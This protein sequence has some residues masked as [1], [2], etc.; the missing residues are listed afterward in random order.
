MTK[1]EELGKIIGLS[2]EFIE[3]NFDEGILDI[4]IALNKKGYY[5]IFSCEGH[6]SPKPDNKGKIGKWE[7]YLAFADTYKF[8]EYPPK[9][10]KYNN[11]RRFFYWNG[12]GEESRK[13]YLD[14]VLTWA[15]TLPTRDKKKVV[16]YH[17]LGRN[18]KQPNREPKLFYYGEDYEEIRCIMNRADISNYFDFELH[19]NIKYI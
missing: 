10:Y 16:V 3:E 2:A 8:K 1:A 19:E 14:N 7:G 13:E 17:L 18:K 6:C 4:L 15:R 12:Y 11:H 5:T 9:F